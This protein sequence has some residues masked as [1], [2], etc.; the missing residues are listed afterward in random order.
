MSIR[1]IHVFISHAWKYSNNYETLRKWIF[2]FP[3]SIGQAS[4]DLRNYSVPKDDP[5]HD[6]PND[7]KLKEAIFRQIHMSHVVVI[8]AGMYAHH[9]KWIRKEIDGARAYGKPILG[10][11]LWGAE[12]KSSVVLSNADEVVGW[13]RQP[14]IDAIWKLYN[15]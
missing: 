1:Q 8:A 9:S 10:V 6:A 4:L 15:R 3:A 13:N 11:N 5:I 2:D 7:T 14:I 12:R